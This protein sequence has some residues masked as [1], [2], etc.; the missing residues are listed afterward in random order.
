MVE[1]LQWSLFAKIPNGVELLTFSQE[2][3]HPRCLP[4]LKIGFWLRV[5]HI[6]LTSVPNYKLSRKKTQQEK[7]CHI[8]FEKE[9]ERGRK[10]NRA[11]VVKQPSE[12]FFKKGVMRNFAELTTKHL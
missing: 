5:L 2:K 11:S 1:H 10:V 9:K 8:V 7:M 3:L 4:R 6:E 12:G